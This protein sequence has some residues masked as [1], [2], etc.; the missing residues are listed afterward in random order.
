MPEEGVQWIPH[1]QILSFEEIIEVVKVAADLGINKVR[2]TGGEPLVRKGIV[3]LVSKINQVEG[4]KD[5]SMTTNGILLPQFANE[6]NQAGMQRVNISLDSLDA[7]KYHRMSRV[8]ILKNALDGIFAAK[9]AGFD[10][11]KINMVVNAETTSNERLEMKVFCEKNG[12]HLRYI[13]EMDLGAGDFT[14]VEGG[15]GGNCALCNRIRL[16]AKGDI[17]P[18]LFSSDGYNV[19]DL[20][21]EAAI[22]MAIG[23]KPKNGQTNEI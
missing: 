9:K 10:P 14:K 3:G 12:L 22:K 4:I 21:A 17:V 7:E 5:I 19:R 16:T 1:H 20:G 6:L 15:D 13:H 23:L 18:C 8:G 11:I 2:L